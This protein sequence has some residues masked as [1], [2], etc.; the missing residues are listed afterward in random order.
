MG[1]ERSGILGC[2]IGET[3]GTSTRSLGSGL[4]TFETRIE[5]ISSLPFF[6]CEMYGVCN[7]ARGFTNIPFFCCRFRILAEWRLPL[8]SICDLITYYDYGGRV[9]LPT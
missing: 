2:F 9:D 7:W 5:N 4:G 1:Y 8:F 3:A 6:V